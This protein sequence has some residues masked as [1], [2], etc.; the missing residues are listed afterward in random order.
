MAVSKVFVDASLCDRVFFTKVPI[1]RRKIPS[2]ICPTSVNIS[3]KYHQN[4]QVFDEFYP[5]RC[6]SLASLGV[7][8]FMFDAFLTQWL[9]TC[10]SAVLRM[11]RSSFQQAL[12]S[13][14]AELH[15]VMP[16]D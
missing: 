1:R 2:Q 6:L 11:D 7:T 15:K 8:V 16:G 14:D 5:T 9:D 4:Q 12:Q 13:D 10:I 3:P